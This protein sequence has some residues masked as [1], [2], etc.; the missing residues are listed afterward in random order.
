MRSRHAYLQ[1]NVWFMFRHIMYYGHVHLLQ[2]LIITWL[3]ILHFQFQLY[4]LIAFVSYV[5]YGAIAN[6]LCF[7]FCKT[8]IYHFEKKEIIRAW[9]CFNIFQILFLMQRKSLHSWKI[10]NDSLM[11]S[12]QNW[13]SKRFFK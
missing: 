3:K 6:A 9:N 5:H 1:N 2:I 8:A 4:S 7:P 12:R 13:Y 11:Y 10:H